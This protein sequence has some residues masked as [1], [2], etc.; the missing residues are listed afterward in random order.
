M[1]HLF[2]GS[3]GKRCFMLSN[4]WSWRLTSQL[5]GLGALTLGF[6][7]LAWCLDKVEISAKEAEQPNTFALEVS[8]EVDAPA[9]AVRHVLLRQCQD[10]NL[11]GSL[12]HCQIFKV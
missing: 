12:Q 6:P 5:L 8:A 10:K 7:S 4:S 9:L 11:S 1:K 3:A 2:N